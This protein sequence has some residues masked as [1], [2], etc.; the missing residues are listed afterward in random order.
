MS[1]SEKHLEDLSKRIEQV[2]E[3]NQNLRQQLTQLQAKY[4]V[5]QGNIDYVRENYEEK[6]K[7]LKSDTLLTTVLREKL[8]SEK[9]DI[10]QLQ[11]DLGVTVKGNDILK[12]EVQNALDALSYA[13]P[14]LKYIEL[15]LTNDL[16]EYMK[17]LGIVKA[18]LTKVFQERDFMWEEVKSYSEMNMLLNYEINM[19]KRKVDTLDEDFLMKEGQITILKDSIDKPFDLLYLVRIGATI[20]FSSLRLSLGSYKKH[21]YNWAVHVQFELYLKMVHGPELLL[22]LYLVRIGAT[23]FFS[24]L[25]LSLGSYKKHLYNWAVHVQFE[26]YLKMVH[27]PEL[28]LNLNST[29]GAAENIGTA[30]KPNGIMHKLVRADRPNAFSNNSSSVLSCMQIAVDIPSQTAGPSTFELPDY[31]LVG[32]GREVRP[33]I[34]SL[35]NQPFFLTLEMDRAVVENV[36]N[37]KG[38]RALH[39]RLLYVGSL[40]VLLVYSILYGLTAKESNWLGA[41]TSAAVIILGF[42]LLKSRVVVLF[43]AGISRVFL[44][45]FGVHYCYAVVVSVLLGA[46]VTWHLSVTEPLAARRDALQSTVICLREGFHRKDQNSSA[47][48]SEECGS[49]I[50]RSSSADAGHLGNA[51]M[52]YTGSKF[53]FLKVELIEI[54]VKA[55]EG[56]HSD[57]GDT[58]ED[59]KLILVE[60]P[61]IPR[62]PGPAPGSIPSMS[63]QVTGIPVVGMYSMPQGPPIPHDFQRNLPMSNN[64]MLGSG[65]PNLPLSSSYN[66]NADSSG[67]QYQTQINNHRFPSG[68]QPWMPISNHNVNF[69]TTMQ[70]T[71]ELVAPL[72]VLALLTLDIPFSFPIHHNGLLVLAHGAESSPIAMSPA[73]NLPTIVASES[74]SLSGKVSS[75]MI[76]TVK[77]KNSSEPTSPAVANLE[78]IGIAVTLGN[79]V[80]PP[81]YVFK[82]IC[83]KFASDAAITEIRGAT[84]SDEKT[85]ELG[86][87]V[88]ESKAEAKN[89]FKTLLESANIGSDCMIA[90]SC[91]HRQDGGLSFTC[92]VKFSAACFLILVTILRKSPYSNIFEHDE[93]FKAVERAKDRKDLFE[94]YVEELEK[95]VK[96][97]LQNLLYLDDKSQ[98]KDAIRMVE[99]R[100]TSAWTLD[101]FKVA[102]DKIMGGEGLLL[103]IFNKFVNELKQKERN[104]QEDKS[105]EVSSR[106][107]VSLSSGFFYDSGLGKK[108]FTNLSK[109]LHG[110]SKKVHPKKSG[111]DSSRDLSIPV[112]IQTIR[113]LTKE[114]VQMASEVLSMLWNQVAERASAKEEASILQAKID[115]WTRRLETK[116]NEL[117]SILEK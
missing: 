71:G 29:C 44:I 79:F 74:S 54:R 55:L 98:I 111:R 14:K 6:V 89:A 96:L 42:K 105:K 67:S 33:K 116:K 77:M 46:A 3:E 20:F 101:D 30:A 97:L 16:Q 38:I 21:L 91:H 114:K 109:S 66:V 64:H 8:Y 80:A 5:A 104:S 56:M 63:L 4:R 99:I 85:V 26:L 57:Y 93:R 106:R 69:A 24:S 81:V 112:L 86:P 9:M 31:A 37:L 60:K 65:G 92:N 117:Q 70:K 18:I 2:S 35:L 50:K 108:N 49:G 27:G 90:R 53:E 23:I 100:L 34:L 82:F 36:F 68:V 84:P 115:S 61:P 28:L 17:E 13:T 1:F 39:L 78:K 94:D 52:P 102:I 11:D 10:K 113:R 75:P 22:N 87:L 103:E 47:S 72:V 12:C 73:A 48:S 25:R 59:P 83:Y 7:E 88:Y 95:K 15:Q 19:L 62:L 43:V 51:T 45:Y 110:H 32:P 107:S 40:V 41:T 58:H 76:E